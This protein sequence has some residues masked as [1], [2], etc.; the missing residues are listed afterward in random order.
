LCR[1]AG[2]ALDFARRFERPPESLA[3]ENP[4]LRGESLAVGKMV[5]VHRPLLVGRMNLHHNRPSKEELISYRDSIGLRR[6]F[7]IL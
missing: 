6:R 2:E 4:K 3:G 5:E 7:W 1:A